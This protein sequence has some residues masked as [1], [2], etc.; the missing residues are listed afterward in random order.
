ML[1]H[2]IIS[3]FTELKAFGRFSVNTPALLTSLSRTY[4]VVGGVGLYTV[5]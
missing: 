4:S 2:L 3:S 1:S 5:E